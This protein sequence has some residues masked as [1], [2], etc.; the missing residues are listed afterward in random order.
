[1]NPIEQVEA[2]TNI[3]QNG[4]SLI[5]IYHSHLHGPCKPSE[6]DT[7]ELAYPDAAYLIF[8]LS[9]DET[10]LCGFRIVSGTWLEIAVTITGHEQ[11]S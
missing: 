11:L 9:T 10:R 5:A 2:F 4:W 8:D 1:M 7:K 3:E 6:T